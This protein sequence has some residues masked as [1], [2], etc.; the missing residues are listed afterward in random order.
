MGHPPTPPLFPPP[1]P[2]HPQA[3]P[4]DQTKPVDQPK[5]GQRPHER[6]DRQRR[7]EEHT[8]ELQS[9]SNLVCRLLLEKK[10]NANDRSAV[11]DVLPAVPTLTPLLLHV[12]RQLA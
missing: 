10:N 5:R 9:Q 1:P 6:R 11:D 12:H 8:S 3:C 2:S 7:S 4:A